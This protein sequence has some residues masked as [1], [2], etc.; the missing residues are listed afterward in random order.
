MMVRIDT[1]PE[2]SKTAVSV[3][4]YLSGSGVGELLRTCHS[5]EGEIVLDLSGLRSA[6]PE[7]IK[8]IREL[9]RGGAELREASPFIR[10]LLDDRE[11]ADAS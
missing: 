3:A 4:G 10:L 8:A 5:I 2:D 11:S 1:S 9:V 6:D 7:G